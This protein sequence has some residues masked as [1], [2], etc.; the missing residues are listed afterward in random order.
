MAKCRRC[1][2]ELPEETGRCP[3][4]GGTGGAATASTGGSRVRLEKDGENRPGPEELTGR[5]T[6]CGKAV[7][8]GAGVCPHCG[9]LLTELELKRSSARPG[10]KIP[11][12]VLGGGCGLLC[13]LIIFGVVW[14]LSALT[15][16]DRK[17]P[18]TIREAPPVVQPRQEPSPRAETP[19]TPAQTPPAP[20]TERASGSRF[21]VLGNAY[22]CLELD[23]YKSL[24]RTARTGGQA[25]VQEELNLRVALGKCRMLPMGEV[26]RVEAVSR[27]DRALALRLGRDKELWWTG[28]HM[29]MPETGR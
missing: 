7:K 1:G 28:L 19:K 4:C 3:R 29:L 17:E 14:L 25:Q 2:E 18:K 21:I 22:G 5:C 24:A 20:R 26:G 13:V 9:E 8:A 16:P 10:L 15:T 12:G 27:P 23:D 11:S 6:A